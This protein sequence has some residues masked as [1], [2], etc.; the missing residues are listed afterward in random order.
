MPGTVNRGS[1]EAVAET[2]PV[3]FSSPR[4]IWDRHQHRIG[5]DASDFQQ[6]VNGSQS[7]SAIPLHKVCGILPAIGLNELRLEFGR[8][9]PP[10]F[11]KRIDPESDLLRLLVDR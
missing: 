2:G 11:L 8:F 7:I 3:I 10:Q 5:V 6:Y 4:L 1:I 9:H